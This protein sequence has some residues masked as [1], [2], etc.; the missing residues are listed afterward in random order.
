VDRN[1]GEVEYPLYSAQEVAEEWP[2]FGS[3]VG[4]LRV[5]DID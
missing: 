5:R 3:A 1:T 4:E 2:E